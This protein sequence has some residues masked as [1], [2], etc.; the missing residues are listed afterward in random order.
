MAFLRRVAWEGTALGVLARIPLCVAVEA[1]AVCRC[2]PD[3][4]IPIEGV[5]VGVGDVGPDPCPC[6]APISQRFGEEGWSYKDICRVAR[7]DGCVS[8]R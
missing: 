7:W 8:W 1:L 2:G 5:A 3:G 6:G 4:A